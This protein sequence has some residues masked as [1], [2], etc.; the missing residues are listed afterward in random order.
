MSYIDKKHLTLIAML[1]FLSFLGLF[2][3]CIVVLIVA[4]LYRGVNYIKHKF[5][6]KT[7]NVLFSFLM[8]LFLAIG[9][10]VFIVDIYLIPSSSM[11]NTLYPKDVILVNKLKYG[12]ILP[13]SPYDIPLLNIFYYLK[14]SSE[15]A[16][17]EKVWDYNRLSGTGSIKQG[18]VIVFKN[19]EIMVKRCV[20]IAG[21]TLRIVGGEVYINDV[22]NKSPKHVKNN[23]VFKLKNVR[24]FYSAI[25]TLE[26]KSHVASIKDNG[27]KQANLSYVEAEQIRR[28]NC[29][30]S[31]SIKIADAPIRAKM[32]PWY[33]EKQWTLDNYGPI[34]IPKKGMEIQLNHDSYQLYKYIFKTYENLDIE[35]QN[36][37]FF[38]DGKPI[39]SYIFKKNY[40][41]MMGDHRKDSRDSRYMGFIPEENI[42]GKVSCVLFSNKDNEFQWNRLFKSI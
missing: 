8:L 15:K 2:W 34:V 5:I 20:A 12:P 18:D 4:L 11:E 22:F 38:K 10:R 6:R 27:R 1:I 7:A 31:L 9:V 41:F 40:Y 29:I 13:Q 32:F 25:D 14:N 19:R 30:D 26:I 33:K 16:V 37:L 35:E 39:S 42:I 24:H 23:Y 36:N 21:D 17:K 3:L 28:L